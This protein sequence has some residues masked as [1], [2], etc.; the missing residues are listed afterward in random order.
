MSQAHFAFVTAVEGFPDGVPECPP[1]S[2]VQEERMQKMEF[3]PEGIQQALQRLVGAHPPSMII[4]RSSVSAVQEPAAAAAPT[5]GTT[6]ATAGGATA[7][8]GAPRREHRRCCSVSCIPLVLHDVV[9]TRHAPIDVARHS[10]L[11]EALRPSNAN[12]DQVLI[13]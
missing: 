11:G 10:A 8:A 12:T 7:P 5:A 3:A 1:R 2:E 13:L 4:R 9:I 6:G